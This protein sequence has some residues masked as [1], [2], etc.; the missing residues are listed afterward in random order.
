MLAKALWLI[1]PLAFEVSGSVLY[2][3][4]KRRILSA[5][6]CMEV[7][8]SF[9]SKVFTGGRSPLV[10]SVSVRLGEHKENRLGAA[11]SGRGMSIACEAGKPA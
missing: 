2:N 5:R 8:Q 1:W 4:M 6:A 3:I 9:S 10:L 11:W 7:L